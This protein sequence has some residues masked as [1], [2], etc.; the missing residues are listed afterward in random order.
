MK[1]K[2]CAYVVEFQCFRDCLLCCRANETNNAT[3]VDIFCILLRFFFL[4]CHKKPLL[5][6]ICQVKILGAVF[7][8]KILTFLQRITQ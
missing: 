5:G 8:N 6:N 3:G 2:S 7:R 4:S 1:L